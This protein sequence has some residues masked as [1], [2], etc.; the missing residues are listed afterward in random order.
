M[1]RGIRCPLRAPGTRFC[2][3]DGDWV[4]IVKDIDYKRVEVIFDSGTVLV[5]GYHHLKAGEFKDYMKKTV[6]GVGCV[7]KP[8]ISG[9]QDRLTY[10]RWHSI[11][12]RCYVPAD[13]FRG[14]EDVNVSEEWLNY[15][16]FNNWI[17]SQPKGN[18]KGWHIDKDLL[19]GKEYSRENCVI[20][21]RDLNVLIS[22]YPQRDNGLPRGI[23]FIKDGTYEA[24]ISYNGKLNIL[25]GKYDSVDK[26]SKAYKECKEMRVKE[27]TQI[28]KSELD[29]RAYEALMN[30]KCGGVL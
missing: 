4:T 3:D 18:S 27:I 1:T 25:V 23:I 17:C 28:Y 22:E 15:S 30:W 10:L 5:T 21:P 29:T 24:R 16:N 11:L 2:N 26:A 14:Y 13:N 7:G 20:L 8:R 12:Q 6:Y 19:G 9:G